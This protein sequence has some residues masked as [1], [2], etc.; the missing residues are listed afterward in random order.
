MSREEQREDS[1]LLQDVAQQLNL[2]DNLFPEVDD[3]QLKILFA[4]V[5]IYL[6]RCDN[7]GLKREYI[8]VNPQLMKRL[9]TS[10]FDPFSTP[11]RRVLR[12]ALV[13]RLNSM[14]KY[15]I[16]NP[17]VVRRAII[18]C[19]YDENQRIRRK[20]KT[21]LDAF[22]RNA[23]ES[24]TK[25]AEQL[26]V[27]PQAVSQANKA[28]RNSE[29]FRF[30]GYIN[31]PKFKLRHF[32]VF[33][34]VTKE[35]LGSSDCAKRLL[36]DGMPFALSLN[37]DIY[38]GKSWAS[39]VVPDQ[40]K[41]LS[42]FRNSLTGLKGE[43]FKDLRISEFES[44]AIGSNLEFFDGKR[45]FFDPQLWTYGFFEFVKQNKDILKKAREFHYSNNAM[46]FDRVDLAVAVAL[47]TDPLRSHYQ[48]SRQLGEQGCKVSRATVTRRIGRLFSKVQPRTD[49]DM[50][51]LPAIYPYAAYS[52]MGLNNLSLYLIE[53]DEK[54]T[55]EMLYAVGYLPYYFLYRTKNGILLSLKLATEDVSKFNYMINGL[56][57]M[58]LV[59]YSNRFENMGIK[60]LASLIE[61]W[62]ETKQ[63]WVCSEGELDFLRRF[64]SMP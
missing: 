7:P 9:T 48:I 11:T 12:E 18:T 46:R 28:M 60:S 56:D 41:E 49:S 5:R 13:S 55:E 50:D 42:E 47:A 58:N 10:Y 44:I 34:T 62:D 43:V 64:E 8:M 35:Y 57:G 30:W 54:H 26:G 37:A 52:G 17:E 15:R 2:Y 23:G 40:K 27:T 20:Q 38:E 3:N 63:R 45:W 14:R 4:L 33:F 16:T 53:C 31:Y 1:I 39:F 29:A 61:R 6:A 51:S 25:I 21:Y 32:I 36:F 19:F 22:M 59:A 24:F